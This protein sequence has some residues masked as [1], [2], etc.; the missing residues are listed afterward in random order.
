MRT[1]FHTG[2]TKSYQWRKQQLESLL[3]CLDENRK[4]L[5]EA[6]NKDLRKSE[7]EAYVF[8]IDYCKN[9]LID[10]LNN[11]QQWM[12]PEKVKKGLLNIMDKAYINREPY[13]VSLIIG[14]WNY[15][16]QLALLPLI[17]AVSAGNCVILK[18]SEVSPATATILEE[19]LP[20][21]MDNECIKVVTGGIPETTALLAE[22]FDYIFYTGNST[23][24]RI[25][26]KA[27]SNYLTPVTL[28]LG[29]KSPVYV[30]NNCDL[31][32]VAKRILWGK[33]CN[34]GQICIAPDYVMCQ[35]EVQ[36]ELVTK[37][38]AS[39]NEFYPGGVETSP[40]YGR[41]VNERHF[42]RLKTV[43][44]GC[45][46][47]AVGGNMNEQDKFISPTIVP[48]VT[49]DHIT[50]QHEIFGPILPIMPVAD[51]NAA[52]EFI[53]SGEKPLAMYVFSNSQ[54]TV[55]NFV[56]NTTSG[57]VCVNDTL[58]Q[59]GLTTL[60]FGGVGNSGTGNY[61]GRFTY[62]SFSHR[63]AVLHKG[64]QMEAVNAMRYPP[65]SEKKMGLIAKI[66]GKKLNKSGL[67]SFLPYV[68]FGTL[69]AVVLK[70][71]GLERVFPSLK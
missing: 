17:G 40:D 51:S 36:D 9:D 33:T 41:I 65:F 50:M 58:M 39:I 7:M 32:V 11:L 8:E 70:T 15:P 56:N 52:V 6:L 20:K 24:G 31:S 48:D 63:R 18:P 25:V 27:A 4:Q 38:K 5:G 64:L 61:H 21:Y 46:N 47:V 62:E 26:M 42:Q 3:K 1:V 67:M 68:I 14:A 37:L 53:N 49:P 45:K 35:K 10:A 43:L 12:K 19:L 55:D 57:N 28:E 69:I 13:G 22:R 34:A 29:G 71:L 23:V 16:V 44:D 30:D 60:P 2:K 66:T 59:A 54:A